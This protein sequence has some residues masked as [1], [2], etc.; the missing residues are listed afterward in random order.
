MMQ[1]Y[2]EQAKGVLME[3]FGVS[4]EQ[5][6]ELFQTWA[7]Q[8]KRPPEVVA[9]VFVNQVWQGDEPCS[10]RTVARILEH[11]LRNLPDFVCPPH[12]VRPSRPHIPRR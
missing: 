5:A 4:A 11:S 10:D 1:Q 9:E 7:R 6:G 12:A 8:C 3:A 2:L